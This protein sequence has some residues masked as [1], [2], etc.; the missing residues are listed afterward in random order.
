MNLGGELAPLGLDLPGA[1]ARH[2]VGELRVARLRDHGFH[3]GGLV[4]APALRDAAVQARDEC[5]ELALRGKERPV[6]AYSLAAATCSPET[7]A[8]VQLVRS[9]QWAAP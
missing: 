4:L 8:A 3:Y 9:E 7:P 1:D 5:G 6:T 2:A